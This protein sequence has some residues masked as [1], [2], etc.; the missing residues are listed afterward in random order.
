MV[1]TK[2]HALYLFYRAVSISF[3]AIGV[4]YIMLELDFLRASLFLL[5]GFVF[6]ILN[7]SKSFEKI[8]AK[9]RTH[10]TY[11]DLFEIA[12]I[13][14]FSIVVL[15]LYRWFIE[16]S[17]SLELLTISSILFVLLLLT[18]AYYFIKR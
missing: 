5:L 1:F 18:N 4:N 15:S 11:L 17:Y 7:S 9:K 10:S 8:E 3:I 13:I 16:K 14:S 6:T 2:K 12:L